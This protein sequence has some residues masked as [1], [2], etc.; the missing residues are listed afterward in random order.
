MANIMCSELE[1][2]SQW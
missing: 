2:P 1:W